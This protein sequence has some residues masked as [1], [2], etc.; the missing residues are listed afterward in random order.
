MWRSHFRFRLFFF[1]HKQ[2]N[3]KPNGDPEE[4]TDSADPESEELE[5]FRRER[6]GAKNEKKRALCAASGRLH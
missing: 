4:I 1:M 3:C 6:E 2:T 5:R